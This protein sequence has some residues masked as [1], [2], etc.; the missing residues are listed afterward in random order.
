V[1]VGALV[2]WRGAAWG[3][4]RSVA[5]EQWGGEGYV[6]GRG[7]AVCR[8]EQGARGTEGRARQ[9]KRKIGGMQ[10]AWKACAGGRRVSARCACLLL[11]SPVL[12]TPQERPRSVRTASNR[13]L[14]TGTV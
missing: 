3:S 1:L 2:Q 6:G 8:K 7:M 12:A 13:L 11:V 10:H 9:T 14:N 5:V 4:V